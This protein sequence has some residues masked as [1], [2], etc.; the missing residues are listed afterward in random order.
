MVEDESASQDSH[1]HLWGEV[2]VN[3]RQA[4]AYFLLMSGFGGVTGLFTGFAV[5]TSIPITTLCGA[6][7]AVTVGVV[8]VS[9]WS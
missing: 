9:D 4:I 6:I 8:S 2:I 3:T 5:P 7:L 1:Q